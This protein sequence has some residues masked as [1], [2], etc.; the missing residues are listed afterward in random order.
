MEDKLNIEQKKELLN[1]ARKTVAEYLQEGVIPDFSVSDPILN[2]K[3][4]AFVTIHKNGQLRGCIGRVLPG[5]QPLWQ[6]VRDMAIAAATQDSRFFPVEAS[7]LPELEFEISILSVPRKID[8]WRKIELGKDGVILQQG[9]NSALFLPQVATES[10]WSREEF[11][12]HL[13]LKAGLE[14]NCFLNPETEISVF[15]ADVFSE[16]DFEK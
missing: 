3:Q 15:Q 13:C 12:Q 14:P 2:K 6:V 11:L 8:D 5:D 10:G 1:I 9:L 4:G 16:K 7:E